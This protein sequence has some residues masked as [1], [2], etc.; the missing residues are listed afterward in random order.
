MA[1]SIG[2]SFLS[3]LEQRYAYRIT[4]SLVKPSAAKILSLM[5]DILAVVS[6]PVLSE[7]SID[8]PLGSSEKSLV[9]SRSK[10]DNAEC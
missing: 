2:S 3:A 5:I 10:Y 6:V 8:I 7:Q 4:S 9:S 1:P